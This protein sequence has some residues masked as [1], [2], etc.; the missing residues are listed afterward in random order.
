MGNEGWS[1]KIVS[2]TPSSWKYIGVWLLA[3]G[4]GNIA[5]RIISSEVYSGVQTRDDVIRIMMIGIPLETLAVG[6]VIVAVYS[7][8]STLNMSAVFPWLVGFMCVGLLI[9]LTPL[10]F[11]GLAL[12]WVILYQIAWTAA[13][14]F[15]IRAFFKSKGRIA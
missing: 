6:V 5:S 10:A 2:D 11:S 9:S 13:M 8:F 14:L 7:F 1:I 3:S 12:G 4:L 15:G